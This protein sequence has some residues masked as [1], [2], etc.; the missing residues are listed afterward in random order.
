MFKKS[1]TPGDKTPKKEIKEDAPK[2]T[3]TVA[4]A[5]PT[6]D[7]AAPAATEAAKS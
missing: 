4:L 2:E 5:E 3:V 6:T 1:D 7:K